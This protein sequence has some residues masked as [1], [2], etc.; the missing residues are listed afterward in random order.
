MWASGALVL[1]ARPLLPTPTTGKKGVAPA[2]GF[3]AGAIVVRFL[4]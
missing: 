1:A 4:G 2:M 3:A